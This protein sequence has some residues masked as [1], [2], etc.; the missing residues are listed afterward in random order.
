MKEVAAWADKGF[1]PSV[2]IFADSAHADND[3]AKSTACD[4]LVFQGGLVD[5]TSWVPPVVALS[6]AESE[7][8]CYSAAIA[9][10][11]FPLRAWK[12][13]VF[14]QPDRPMTVSI[15][16]DSEAA[17]TMNE[18][19]NPTRRT[20]HIE[21]RFWYGREAVLRR[22]VQFVKVHGGTQQPADPGTK[23]QTHEETRYY[24]GLF[25]AVSYT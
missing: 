6:T 15:M 1:D 18:S 21:S 11:Q 20:R 7:N 25:E 2:M 16:V 23:S 19:D 22:L 9:R 8:N 3:Q 17:I 5:H 12:K 24:R 13:I 14:N 10:M 4:L